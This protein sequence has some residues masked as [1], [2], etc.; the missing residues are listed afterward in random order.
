MA[1]E[2]PSII[3]HVSLGTNNFAAATVFYDKVLAT[4]GAN[5]GANNRAT[6]L[7]SLTYQGE[8]PCAH[9]S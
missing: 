7:S 5:I 1:D 2:I 3:H 8:L 9:S 6:A 4:I